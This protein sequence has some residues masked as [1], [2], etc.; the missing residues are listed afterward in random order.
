[1][2]ERQQNI[3]IQEQETVR[4]ERELDSKVGFN[5]DHD[6]DQAARPGV[7]EACWNVWLPFSLIF[8]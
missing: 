2:V 4:R 5:D 7:L 1:M 6:A 8:T 3:A